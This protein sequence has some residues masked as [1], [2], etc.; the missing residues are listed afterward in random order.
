MLTVAEYF[1]GIGL[2]RLGLEEAGW[3]VIFANDFSPKKYAM[4]SK[5]FPDAEDHFLLSDIFSVNVEQ[6]PI[7]TLATCSF[8]CIDLSLAGKQEGL[9]NGRHSSAFWGFIDI[10]RAQQNLAPQIVMLENVNGWLSSNSGL[11]FRL[12]IQALNSLGYACDVFT[13]DA[14]RFVPQSRPRV[15]V[16]G[17][18]QQ[19]IGLGIDGFKWRSPALASP[20]LREV[21]QANADLN[22]MW[23]P[24][25]E[26]PPIR[27][28]GLSEIIEQL[29]ENDPRWWSEAE[30]TRHLNMMTTR[31]REETERLAN[32]LWPV[33]RTMYRRMRVGQQRVEARNDDISGC[34]RT[35][36]GGSARQMVIKAGEGRIRMRHMTSREYARLQGV[37]D[38]YPISVPETDGLTG[39]GDAVCVP[40]ISWIAHYALTQVIIDIEVNA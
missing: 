17:S 18:R 31:H 25:P 19:N 38:T 2:V 4:Y 14:L 11:D 30:V 9:V 35:A 34:L 21:V 6:V 28:S 39:F 32:G 24:L 37:P 5:A 23:L 40:L 10:L 33:F 8:P 20:R 29:E 1:A 13:L 16:I 12:T 36:G 7:A 27:T 26:P 15:F 3:S 22:W